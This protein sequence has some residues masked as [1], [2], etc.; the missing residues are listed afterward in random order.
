MR[1]SPKPHPDRSHEEPIRPAQSPKRGS[2]DGRLRR[3]QSARAV[4]RSAAS[5]EEFGRNLRDWFHELRRLSSRAQFGEAVR[6]RPLRLAG[7]FAG[8]EIA[9][10][11][12][13]AQVEWLCRR[14]RIPPPRWTRDPA[15][16]LAEPWFST[17]A[18]RLRT[19]LLL[20]T[21][22]EFRNR[23]VFTIPELVPGVRRGRPKVSAARQREKAR[24]RQQ[25]YRRRK[26]ASAR[27][28]PQPP[29]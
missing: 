1:R 13:A 3:P 14:V 6:V 15:Y 24:Q 16:T 29:R 21:P 27:Q 20:D 5:L 22:D 4:V 18:R 25:R 28:G 7:R 10:A 26:A 19:H 11:F 12:L 8:G 23:N 2:L 9:D 17:P